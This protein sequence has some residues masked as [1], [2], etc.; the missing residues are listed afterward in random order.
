[1]NQEWEYNA[2][3]KTITSKLNG[4]C[5]QLYDHTGPIVE[6]YPC[7]NKTYQQWEYNTEDMT[8]RV[9]DRCLTPLE[10][11]KLLEVWAQPLSD[12]SQ[13]VALVNRGSATEKITANFSD[14]GISSSVS[15]RDLW[16][17]TDLGTYSGYFVA[18]VEPHDTVLIK[19][20]PQN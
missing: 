6:V 8:L 2:E 3:D 19:V 7:S 10:D 16:A 17:H 20:T 11:I 4:L 18:A 5:L 14:L 13:A 12:G 9:F 1:M 15:V